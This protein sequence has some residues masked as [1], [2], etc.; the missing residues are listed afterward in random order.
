MFIFLK[1]GLC[2]LFFHSS[3][4]PVI[5][6]PSQLGGYLMEELIVN[7][8]IEANP[9]QY[10]VQWLKNGKKLKSGDGV[11]VDK[12]VLTFCNL[13]NSD[14][15]NYTITADNGIGKPSKR[16]FELIAFGKFHYFY[17]YLAVYVCVCMWYVNSLSVGILL[18][19]EKET[20]ANY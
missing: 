16:V 17:N 20:S 10:T 11:N 9:T 5:T 6:V 12:N 3:D 15:G 14:A 13:T 4:S 1:Q 8:S 18:S 19:S 2:D 7:I